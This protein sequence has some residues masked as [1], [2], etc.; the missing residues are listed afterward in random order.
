MRMRVFTLAL[1]A[2]LAASGAG[3][4]ETVPARLTLDEALA[5]AR[6]E[7]PTYLQAAN[8]PELSNWDVRQ[9]WG[10]LLPGASVGGSA[11]WQGSGNQ[12]FGALTLSQLGFGGL[13]S[14]YMSSYD[15]SVNYSLSWAKILGP[16]QANAN[17]RTTI[18]NTREAEGTMVSQVTNAYVQMLR[19]QEAVALARQQVANSQLNLRLAEGRQAVGSATTIDVGQAQ[20]QLGRDSVSLLQAQ[21]ALETA[22][23][24]LLQQMGVSGDRD[25]TLT[26]QFE[27]T[28]PT[29]TLD[30]LYARAVRQNPTLEARLS[31]RKAAAIGVSSARS[32]YYPTLSISMGLSGFT[33]EASNT[34]FEVAQAQAAVQQEVAQ[35]VATN[36][37]YARLA[38]PLPPMDCSQFAFT[39]A[40]RQAIINHNNQFPFRFQNSPLTVSVGVSIPIF[41]GL[42]RQRSLEAAELQR[43]DADQQVRQQEIA[44][45]ADLAVDLANVKAAYQS[46]LLEERNQKLA[47]EQLRLAREQYEVGSITFV[48][49]VNAE[50]VET[51]ANS[52]R[53]S[54]VYS[55]HD[56]VT[57]LETLVGGSL[58]N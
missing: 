7:N 11:A 55:Y 58:R 28:Q 45:R 43:Q 1:G 42:T 35:C 52:D 47:E 54:A 41:Q 24:R 29:W 57:S 8:D 9:A 19:E 16:A 33:Q 14:Y 25:I 51:Q 48:D 46:A 6:H 21:T 50:T 18:A 26:T 53:L 38:E 15:L 17:R 40:Q 32:A 49:L 27:L 3:A 2:V 10:Q 36:N 39:D 23:L 22:R 30:E 31:A 12:Q 5:I 4:Q 13:P 37:I 34:N 20:V 56:A 44:L